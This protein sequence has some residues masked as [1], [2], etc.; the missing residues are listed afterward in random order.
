[1]NASVLNGGRGLLGEGVVIGVGD[2]ATILG[3]VDFSGRILSSGVNDIAPHGIHVSGT[4]TG[5]G[6]INQ[7][8][9]G[10]APRAKIASEYFSNVLFNSPR[11]IQDYNMV[12]T[13]NSYGNYIGCGTFGVYET[14]ANLVDQMAFDYPNLL[15]VFASGNSG[16]AG[17]YPFPTGF[18][19][20]LGGYQSSK[21]AL[22]V[23]NTTDSGL[24]Y[25]ASSKGP[26]E[27]GRIKPEVTAMGTQVFSNGAFNSYYTNTGTSMASPAVAGGSA[28]LYQRYRQLS[29][30]VDPESALV[31]ALICNGATD[32]GNKGPDYSYGFGWMNLQR[33]VDM[34]ENARFFQGTSTNGS[35]TIN[36]ITVPPNTAQLK[37][38]LY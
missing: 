20:V 31:K 6:I 34:L 3:N 36:N 16:T 12:V 11:L 10:Y 27:D 37:I 25:H 21:N 19:N 24:I 7:G 32:R 2:N 26:V 15:N 22:I 8:A 4:A 5:A 18:H 23:G 35:V 38:M 33:S 9:R 14:T 29:G 17:C 1:M 13:N 28:L 30:G